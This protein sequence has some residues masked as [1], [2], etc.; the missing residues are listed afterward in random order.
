MQFRIE[1]KETSHWD[2]NILYFKDCVSILKCE[3]VTPQLPDIIEDKYIKK[4]Y[5]SKNYV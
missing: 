1:K 4:Y 3:N 5:L 2:K